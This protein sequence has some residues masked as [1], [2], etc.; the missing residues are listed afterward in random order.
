[1]LQEEGWQ[2]QTMTNDLHHDGPH[3][4]MTDYEERFYRQGIF[5]NRLEAVKTTAVKTSAD[6]KPPRLRDAALSDARNC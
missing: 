4:V 5:I 1:M 6:G 2:L 3:G